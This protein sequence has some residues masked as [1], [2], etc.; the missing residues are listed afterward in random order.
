[1]TFTVE[2]PAL[3]GR[4]PLGFLAALGLHRLL[5]QQQGRTVRL[6]FSTTSGCAVI[7]SELPTI[8]AIAA[9]LHG[10]LSHAGDDTAIIGVDD[11]FPLRKPGR[12]TSR[13]SGTTD[14]SDPMRVPRAQYPQLVQ[15]VTE[16]GEPA[17]RWLRVLVTDLAVDGRGRA[18]L[19]PY[20]APSGQQSLRSFFAT[21]LQ[22]VRKNP[23]HINE[24]LEGWR[25]ISDFTGEYLDHRAVQDA[26]QHPEGKPANTG[27]P[28]ATWLATQALLLFRLTGDGQRA[29]ATLWHRHNGR[30][31]MI[32]PLWKHPLDI[33]ATRTLLEHPALR[34]QP[35]TSTPSVDNSP[36]RPLGIFTVAGAERKPAAKS[37]GVLAP[38]TI[39]H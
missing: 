11:R 15:R 2:L 33:T 28:G 14:E 34:P 29:T 13:G 26:A 4:D 1:M 35:V 5:T 27:V 9:T 10:L 21:P 12:S 37:A 39:T 8:D 32:W 38:L 30:H 19:T 24:A 16:L 7:D 18:A 22:A 17:V 3:D 31:I 25:R 36:L 23:A 20:C 6:F